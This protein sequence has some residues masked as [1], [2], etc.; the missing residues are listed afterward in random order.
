VYAVANRRMIPVLVIVGESVSQSIP[1]SLTPIAIPTRRTEHTYSKAV[2]EGE[3][4]I[5]NLIS[6]LSRQA[7]HALH[8]TCT[9]LY[10]SAMLGPAGPLDIR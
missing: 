8:T 4:Y 9:M 6:I 10:N 7:F 2:R 3:S 5:F 1:H